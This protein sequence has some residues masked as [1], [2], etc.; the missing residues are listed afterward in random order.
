MEKMRKKSCL[1]NVRSSTVFPKSWPLTFDFILTFVFHFLM[2]DSDPNS[3]PEPEYSETGRHI[4]L[5]LRFSAWW[6]PV[7]GYKL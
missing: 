7:L 6:I 2:W 3:V 5:A 4:D 1:F